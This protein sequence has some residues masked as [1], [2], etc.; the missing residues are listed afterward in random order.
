M[1]GIL[2]SFRAMSSQYSR[3]PLYL[4][5]HN[6]ECMYFSPLFRTCLFGLMFREGG[7]FTFLRKYPESFSNQF[8]TTWTRWFISVKV[9]TWEEKISPRSCLLVWSYINHLFRRAA[10]R[11]YDTRTDRHNFKTN[12]RQRDAMLTTVTYGLTGSTLHL[13]KN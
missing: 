6:F 10:Y 8:E 3:I 12:T 1:S 11:T 9:C 4:Y 13:K 5:V 2:G 7:K